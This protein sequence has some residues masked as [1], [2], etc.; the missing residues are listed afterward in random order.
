MRRCHRAYIIFL[1]VA[2]IA[3]H[4]V[5]PAQDATKTITKFL[6]GKGYGDTIKWDFNCTN[7]RNSGK[8]STI[9]V[10]SC[11]EQEGFGQY[12][13]GIRFY[14]KATD[15]EIAHEQG[16]YRHAF[17][18]PDSWRGKRIK[19]VFDGSMTD[20]EVFING[21]KAGATHQGGF[22]RFDYDITDKL[23]YGSSNILEVTVSKESTNASVN[24]AERRADYWNFGGIFRPVFLEVVPSQHIDR[25]AIDARGDGNFVAE[26]YL[27]YGTDEGLT[28][29]ARVTDAAGRT[30]GHPIVV[31][32]SRGSDR[33][34]LKGHY[35][36]VKRWTAETPDLYHVNIAL[37]NTEG[38]IVHAISERFGFRTFEIKAGDGF[39]LNGQRIMLKGINR[40]SFWPESGRTLNKKLNYEDVRLIKEMNMNTV[41]LSHY[42]AD[43]EFLDAC[44]ELG[45][46]VLN[47]LTGWHGK[48]DEG[49]GRKLVGE[50]VRRDVNHPS[51][52][53]WDNGNEGGWNT[54]LDD[55][56]ARWDPQR[57]PVLHPQQDLS[58]VETMHYRSYGE[59]QEYL[60]GPQIFF[61]T[62]MLHGLY[63]GG[64][65][66]GLFDYWEMMKDHPRCGGAL[67]WVY[68][69]EGV[70]RTDQDGRI[71]NQGNFGAD[72]IVGPHRQKEAS[73]YTVKEIWSPVQLASQVLFPELNRSL[74]VENRYDFTNLNQCT[75]AWSLAKFHEPLT[76]Q[77]GHVVIAEGEIK[78]PDVQP[79]ERG[80]VDLPLSTKN[81]DADVLYVT[82]KDPRGDSLWTWSWDLRRN[83]VD[84]TE[85]KP[86]SRVSIKENDRTLVADDGERQYTFDKITGELTSVALG[87]KIFSLGN[88][89]RFI[90]ARRGDR[91][92][93]G[94]VDASAPKNVDRIY[95]EIHVDQKLKNIKSEIVGSTVVISATYDG[96]L[97]TVVWTIAP[98]GLLELEYEYRYDGV[99]ELMGVKFEYPEEKMKAVRWLGQGPYRVWQNRMHGLILDVWEK[100]YNDPVPGESFVYPE[101]KGYHADWRWAVFQTDEGNILFNNLS[102]NQDDSYLG[103]YAPRDGRDALLYALPQTGLAILD[104]IPA[105]RNKVNATDLV[106]PSSQPQNVSGSRIHRL[107]LKFE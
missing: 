12:Q 58:G 25:I 33:A 85:K 89:P 28:A 90:A 105:V 34:V 95:N 15:P 81:H 39:Y 104:V 72:G 96:A 30:F 70:V 68:T 103:I 78:G 93:D 23:R 22:Y 69:D 42:P 75:F 62:E 46:Y 3:G 7:G 71:D 40:H 13:Y 73:F 27:G 47:E 63:D 45:L 21:R 44:D 16:M 102:K 32:F 55:E 20:T 66:A 94:N 82:A 38:Q 84:L 53:F 97:K 106:G 24:L 2:I 35:A 31:D 77:S 41:R 60:R 80:E 54:A 99:V 18:V 101:F 91:T 64:H 4:H 76:N 98:E 67:L 1:L 48:Y 79:H 88:G 92:L 37:K 8:W 50:L 56:F 59:T 43:P 10:P 11:W 51:I 87:K 57:R 49:V 61:P 5:L 100:K 52:I 74:A 14:G 17:A 83:N 29:E 6:S 26:V 86:H 19:I 65:G 9:H 36:G 107:Q